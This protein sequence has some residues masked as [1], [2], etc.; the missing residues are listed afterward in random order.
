MH[1]DNSRQ[2]DGEADEGEDR[3]SEEHGQPHQSRQ[4]PGQPDGQVSNS[5]FK[6]RQFATIPTFLH[7]TRAHSSVRTTARMQL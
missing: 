6:C 1:V 7:A 5:R 3:Q 4:E 2:E